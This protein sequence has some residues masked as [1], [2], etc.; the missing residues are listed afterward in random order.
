MG[1]GATIGPRA[2]LAAHAR[3]HAGA[4]VGSG[5]RLGVRTVIHPRAALMPGVVVGEDCTIHPG[6]VLGADGFGFL[7]SPAADGGFI[8]V[9]HLAGVEIGDHA[10]IGA[11]ACVD[12]GKFRHTTIGRH[13][14]IDNLVQVGHSCTIGDRV[15]IC[16]CTAI[17]GSTTIGDDVLIGGA[18]AIS[19]NIA[20]APRSILGGGTH[21]AGDI[22]SPGAYAGF[23]AKP[24]A[25]ARR[26][27]AAQS[28]LPKLRDRLAATFRDIHRR[29]DRLEHQDG[30]SA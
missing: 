26:V 12:R 18:C 24:A 3:V 14:K 8:K 25:H 27:F 20:I 22:T 28:Q 30:H 10:E 5:V 6:A 1:P 19:D 2:S 4:V 16:G 11:N 9:P 21:V 7:P 15:R 17:G 23:P 29:L 13:T